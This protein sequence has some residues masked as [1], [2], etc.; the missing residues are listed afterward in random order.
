MNEI[1]PFR[2][3]RVGFKGINTKLFEIT[4][5]TSILEYQEN[6]GF[7]TILDIAMLADVLG[8][9]KQTV[10][11]LRKEKNKQYKF[12][13]I[14]KKGRANKGKF[15]K[16]QEPKD[17]MMYVQK[18]IKSKILD[19]A[20]ALLPTYITGFRKGVKIR[21]T[22]KV[23]AN[24]KIVVSLDL[25]HF[26]NSIK[27]KHLFQLFEEHFKYP[28]DVSRYLSELCTYKFFVPEGSP[29]SPP[30][31]NIVGFFF[32]DEPLKKIAEDHGFAYTR[33]ADDIT[34]ST[35][36]EF[37]KVEHTDDKGNVY[38]KSKIDIVID[39]MAEVL[40]SKG[41]ILNRRKTKIM[42]TPARQYV[43]G[44]VVNEKPDLLR[45]K[46]ELL[47]CILHN[48]SQ[49]SLAEEAA[50]TNRTEMQFLDWIRG[51]INYFIQV[52]E[53]KGKKLKDKFDF[54]LKSKGYNELI[55]EIPIL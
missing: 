8:V 33:Y 16:L 18:Q 1:S 34:L 37:P 15:R 13:T 49:N 25:R 7:P 3:E 38:V 35:D 11:W 40:N 19:P 28:A 12:W 41:F 21:D 54:I 53:I 6:S 42:R 10:S 20:E 47:K 48:M 44:M 2:L 32:F 50:K 30:I 29:S 31:S 23:H 39:S 17:R 27:Q 5:L 26:F 43:L 52:N 22:A 24:K 36:V 46:R 14:P 9:K 45:R 55:M 4:D 51:Q